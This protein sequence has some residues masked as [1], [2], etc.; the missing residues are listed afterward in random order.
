MSA[1]N[2]VNITVLDNPATFQSKLS[3][4]ITLECLQ[5]LSDGMYQ[6]FECYPR[7]N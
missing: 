6:D 2:V 5:E 4:E 3:F 1:V 7:M